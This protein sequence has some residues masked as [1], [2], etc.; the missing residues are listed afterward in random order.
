MSD[1]EHKWVYR[2]LEYYHFG[3]LAGTGARPRYYVK[4]YYCDRCLS[5][6]YRERQ[7]VGTSYEP[8]QTGAIEYAWELTPLGWPK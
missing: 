8:S 4:A 2:G 6:T 5:V 3:Q 1:C 7:C